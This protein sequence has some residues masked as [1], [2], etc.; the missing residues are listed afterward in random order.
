MLCDKRLGLLKSTI[1]SEGQT[2]PVAPSS[3]LIFLR[4]VRRSSAW[5]TSWDSHHQRT[6]KGYPFHFFPFWKICFASSLTHFWEPKM[7]CNQFH[8]PAYH[9]NDTALPLIKSAPFYCFGVFK[10]LF[11]LQLDFT[12]VACWIYGFTT[13]KRNPTWMHIL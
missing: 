7:Q 1:N 8:H 4:I 2:A 10:N 3:S 5:T 9:W 12:W 11:L 6:L 13:R